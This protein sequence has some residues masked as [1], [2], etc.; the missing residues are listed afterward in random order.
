MVGTTTS[1]LPERTVAAPAMIGSISSVVWFQ[2]PA[3][4]AKLT[5][6]RLPIRPAHSPPF[7][8]LSS[9]RI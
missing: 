8:R 2:L 3:F 7:L 4:P 1:T 5:G 6:N 9:L